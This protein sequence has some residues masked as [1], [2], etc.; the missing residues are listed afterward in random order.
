MKPNFDD[1]GLIFRPAD[2][3]Q[4]HTLIRLG[5]AA[6]AWPVER[7]GD[8]AR[9]AFFSAEDAEIFYDGAIDEGIEFV[10]TFDGLE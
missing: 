2:G 5:H 1:L 9:I 3:E 8:L 7:D 4:L 6:E 10:G